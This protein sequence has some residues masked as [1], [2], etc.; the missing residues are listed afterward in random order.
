[1][2]KLPIKAII[3]AIFCNVLFGS[4]IPAIKL[5]YGFFNMDG[6][7]F[8]SILYAGTRFFSAGIVVFIFTLF[9]EKKLPAFKK[10]KAPGVILLGVVYIFLQYLFFYIGVAKV[11]GTI[12][13]ILTASSVFF[14]IIFAHFV[15]KND[16]ITLPKALGSLVGFAG[17][18]IV[19]VSGIEGKGFTFSGEGFVLAS[20]FMFVVGSMINKKVTKDISSFVATAYNFLIG[21]FLL[22]IVG[23][24]G[25]SGGI[26][27]TFDG[28]MVLMYLIFVSSVAT[29]LWSTLLK[30]YPI[31]SLS[32]FNFLIPVSGAILSGVLLKE[33]IFNLKYMA[34]LLLVCGGIFAVNFKIKA[35][36][37]K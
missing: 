19:C 17:V 32:I 14:A 34:S 27:V 21:G 10:T 31:G 25:Y 3:A 37:E 23:L 20:S 12:S 24:F 8:S 15:Y 30:Y 28:C 35:K 13:T 33:N 2:N 26:D 9:Y 1:M 16:K 5:G 36:N 11:P 18:F 4:A 6:D 7:M 22:I 29:T